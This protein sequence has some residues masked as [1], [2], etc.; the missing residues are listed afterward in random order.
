MGLYVNQRASKDQAIAAIEAV[1]N[2]KSPGG[3]E[4]ST[5][6]NIVRISSKDWIVD[7]DRLIDLVRSQIMSGNTRGA[8][9]LIEGAI[10]DRRMYLLLG[11]VIGLLPGLVIGLVLWP[12]R[13]LWSIIR[14]GFK[15]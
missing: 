1:D 2:C 11:L 12:F 15:R 14:L 9:R 3:L 10:P 7:Q 5:C 13:F 8:I 4:Y 6:L